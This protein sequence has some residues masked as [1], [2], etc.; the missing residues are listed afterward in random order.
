MLPGVKLVELE[1]IDLCLFVFSVFF[2]VISD[3]LHDLKPKPCAYSA[4]C[5][6]AEV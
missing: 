3:V 2:K 4:M 1:M 6:N 5:P